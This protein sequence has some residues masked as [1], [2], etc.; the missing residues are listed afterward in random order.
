MQSGFPT[1]PALRSH[2]L[3]GLKLPKLLRP[4]SVRTLQKLVQQWLSLLWVTLLKRGP[5]AM[6]RSIQ[7]VLPLKGSEI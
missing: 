6:H 7:E 4:W 2:V 5:S 3:S 1:C